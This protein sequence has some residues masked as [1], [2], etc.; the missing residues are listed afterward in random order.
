MTE[1]SV[2]A[3]K[4]GRAGRIT[5]NRPKA[6][7][8]LN[9]DMCELMTEALIAWQDDADVEL[10]VVDHADGTRGFCAGGD[11]R[12]LQESGKADGQ[13][14][15]EFFASEYR[16]NTLIKEYNKPYVA[17]QDGVTMG[18]GVGISVHGTY[19]VATPNTLFAMPESGIGL[20]PDV[21]GGWF[22]PR[23][24][25]ATGMWLALTGARLK[26]EDVLAA[27]VATHF[28]EDPAG[29]ADK[30]CEDGVSALDGLK[31]EASRSYAEHQEE[32]DACFGKDSVEDIVAALETGSDWA[33]AQAE[34]LA[35]KSPLTLKVAHRQ[36][37][38]G[39]KMSDFRENMKME[40][41]IGG[42]LVCTENF[43]EGVRAVLIDKDHKPNW[44]PPTLEAV[45]PELVDSFFAPLGRDELTFI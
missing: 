34:T 36:L 16:L 33:K 5:L 23:L 20:F 19:R 18:G 45:T 28:A 22:L 24:D 30:L 42:R 10:I 3:R 32:I 7:H 35:S 8:A 29:L 31:T 40:Y 13:E 15:R 27:G 9:L 38:E 1:P 26:G 6:L 41:R 44:Q 17:L 43:I 25:G 21:G 4:Q 12:M 39:G 37:T 11:I 2:I 14:A